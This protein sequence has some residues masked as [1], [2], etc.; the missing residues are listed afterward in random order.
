MRQGLAYDV[1]ACTMAL[2][3]TLGL[4]ERATLTWDSKNGKIKGLGPVFSEA[5]ALTLVGVSKLK[6]LFEHYYA[7]DK[8]GDQR[9]KGFLD[10]PGKTK[11]IT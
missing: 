4:V 7:T 5:S 1:G 3:V 11:T 2:R 9:F 10:A 6:E 8:E